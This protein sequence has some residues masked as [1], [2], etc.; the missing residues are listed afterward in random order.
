MLME[1]G[2]S[3]STFFLS[4]TQVIFLA[5]VLIIAGVVSLGRQF[6]WLGISYRAPIVVPSGA[7]Y[8]EATVKEFD[9]RSIAAERIVRL[10]AEEKET[11]LPKKIE[12]LA[13][14]RTVFTK[15]TSSGLIR[16]SRATISEG[17][18]IWVYNR[19]RSLEE[20]VKAPADPD[21][22]VP[23]EETLNNPRERLRA[24]FVVKVG[25]K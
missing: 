15:M 11:V 6:E 13:D 22:A 1:T 18:I 9:N 21:L 24:D 20:V 2:E 25:G 10:D 19:V 7:P 23:F 14:E 4:K 12:I 16:I 17:D 8:A 3:R 5:V